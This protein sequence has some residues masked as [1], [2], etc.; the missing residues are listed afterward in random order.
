MPDAM[1]SLFWPEGMIGLTY[2]DMETDATK[3]QGTMD[4]IYQTKDGY[5]TAG[6][7]SDKEGA[8]M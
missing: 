3:F 2:A 7:V 8:G 4:L 6:T 1:L 5:I